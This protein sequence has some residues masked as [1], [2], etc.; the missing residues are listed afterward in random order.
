MKL[1]HVN[2]VGRPPKMKI[3]YTIA[4]EKTT[5]NSATDE[6]YSKFLLKTVHLNTKLLYKNKHSTVFT[7]SRSWQC[8]QFI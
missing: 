4:K 3:N 2:D 5:R 7:S 6:I 8:C 1:I